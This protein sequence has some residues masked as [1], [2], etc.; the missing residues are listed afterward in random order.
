MIVWIENAP[1][2]LEN[3]SKQIIEF[4]DNYLKYERNL[5]ENFFQN[6]KCTNTHKHAKKV[7]KL[8]ADLDF[9]FKLI[10]LL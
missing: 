10:R 6:Y 4:F 5:K 2:Y 1:K 8:F 9:H 3:D 7:E